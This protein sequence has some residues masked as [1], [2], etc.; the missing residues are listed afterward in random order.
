MGILEQE[1]ERES[2]GIL[3][4]EEE[5]ESM[6]ILEQDDGSSGKFATALH[7]GRQQAEDANVQD[8]DHEEEEEEEGNDLWLRAKLRVAEATA[9]PDRFARMLRGMHGTI[10]SRLKGLCQGGESTY[11]HASSQALDDVAP[12]VDVPGTMRRELRMVGDSAEWH[13]VGAEG[14]REY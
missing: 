3:E 11:D 13:E 6:G 5:R 9:N 14:E 7:L 12:A 8:D 2:M 10:A 1:E 4:Q